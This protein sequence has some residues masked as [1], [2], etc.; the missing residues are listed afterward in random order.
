MR[1]S[2]GRVKKSEEPMNRENRNANKKWPG[3]VTHFAFL[4]FVI[5]SACAGSENM[6]KCKGVVCDQSPETTCKDTNTLKVYEATGICNPDTGKCE[7]KYTEQ[8]CDHGCAGNHCPKEFS[9][10]VPCDS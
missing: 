6:N 1:D 8:H 10:R 7:Y 9:K 4:G 3:T 2:A 5:L